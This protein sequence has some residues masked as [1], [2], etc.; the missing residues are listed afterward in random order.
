MGA[1]RITGQGEDLGM[2]NE[3]VDHCG[4]DDVVGEDLAPPPERHVRGDKDR[5][6]FV[7]GGDEL[8]EQVMSQPNRGQSRW[9]YR[10]FDP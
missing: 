6:L 2:V 4:R 10:V 1:V 7:S 9:Q 5:A 3:P 8:E